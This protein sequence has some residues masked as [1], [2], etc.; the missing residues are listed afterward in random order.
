MEVNAEDHRTD[1]YALGIVFWTLLVGRG[2]M[3][4]DGRPRELLQA[5]VHKR[6]LP[7]H[8]VRRGVPQVLAFII[9]KVG[10]STL[11]LLDYL[12]YVIESDHFQ[13]RPPKFFS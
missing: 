7:V 2:R 6:P 3:P 4:F 9:E 5:I 13:F 1:L 10:V 11:P 12:L 8:E